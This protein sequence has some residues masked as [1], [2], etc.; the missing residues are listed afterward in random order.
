MRDPELAGEEA[1]AASRNRRVPTPELRQRSLAEDRRHS[2]RSFLQMPAKVD[3]ARFPEVNKNPQPAR[4]IKGTNLKKF[5]RADRGEKSTQG[6][7][8]SRR[9]ALPSPSFQTNRETRLPGKMR[10]ESASADHFLKFQVLVEKM[11]SFESLDVRRIGV[12][13]DVPAV[14]IPL[15]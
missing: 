6:S 8:L 3:E 2:E 4:K 9:G 10:R 1:Y 12:V 7:S 13:L 14:D 11:V 5:W 15:M